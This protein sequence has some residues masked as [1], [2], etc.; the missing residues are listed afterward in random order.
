MR[1]SRRGRRAG[2]MR[3]E[4]CRLYVEDWNATGVAFKYDADTAELLATRGHNVSSTAWGAVT[5]T[6]P[7]FALRAHRCRNEEQ[8][9]RPAC[10]PHEGREA[11]VLYVEDWNATGVAFKYD[12]DT[13]ELLATRGHNVSSTAWGAVT[14]AILVDADTGELHGVSD[15]RK[16]GAPAAA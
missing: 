15:P 3:W 6:Q 11:A 2:R 7:A 9:K 16:D 1:S 10:G 14:Q 5:Q 13:A 4:G 12:A 8:Q